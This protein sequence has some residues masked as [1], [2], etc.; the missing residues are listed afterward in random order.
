MKVYIFIIR[1]ITYIS[2]AIQYVY[3]K[4]NY[5]ESQGW[6][7]FIFSALHGPLYVEKFE[8]YKDYIYPQLFLTPNCF[9]KNE[10]NAVVNSIVTKSKVM[11]GDYC[12]VE[13][14]AV[15]RSV[16]AE[17]IASRLNCRH[18]ALFV[19]ETHKFYNEEIRDYLKFKYNRHELAGIVDE[20]VNQILNDENVERRADTR[21]AAYCNNV[22]EDI[23]DGF[24]NKLNDKADYTLGYL[25][26]LEKPCVTSI[27]KGMSSFVSR[28]ANK[29][30]NVVMIGG[31][32]SKHM[33][34]YIQDTFKKYPNVNLLLTGYLYPIPLSFVK[35]VNVFVSTAGSVTVTYN[36]GIP[37]VRVHPVTGKPVGIVGLDFKI[38]DKGLYDSSSDLTVDSCI[39]KAI[40]HRDEI[41][42][43]YDEEG[44]YRRMYNEFKR[45]L[46]FV[47]A[48]D[49][50]A[51]Y[52]EERL[53]KLKTPNAH[54][55]VLWILGHLLGANGVNLF[56]KIIHRK[57]K[58]DIDSSSNYI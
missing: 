27:V 44:Y 9:K 41:V 58:Y 20:S 19:R 12:I 46:S 5:L 16:W 43:D 7:V 57:A 48:I 15:Q 42:F 21:F 45:Q 28:Y 36:A 32:T 54:R 52:S 8:K 29:S 40:E 47:D 6:R 17:L 4:T 25:G 53:L 56:W 18:L 10:V 22:I 24:S 50:T 13:S 39:E 37:T 26:R 55:H 14:D 3:N 35:R 33:V 51:F 34:D 49:N 30:I 11:P 31:S 1:R 38:G 23:H 2:G